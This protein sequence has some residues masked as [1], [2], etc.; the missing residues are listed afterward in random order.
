MSL[1]IPL[2]FLLVAAAHDLR[3]R[4]VP[5]W[6]SLALLV[7]AAAAATLGIG[8]LNWLALG[9]GLAIGLALTVPLFFLGGI[10]G[11][12]VKLAAALGAAIGPWPLVQSLFWI[13]LA[14]GA[15]ALVAK[16]RGQRTFAYVPAMFLGL[17]AFALWSAGW[18]HA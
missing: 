1:L 18:S 14:G 13:A 9:M 11:A 8:E 10:G 3:R 15:L 4:E 5:D 17:A 2:L 6:I 7:W 12:D 16:C